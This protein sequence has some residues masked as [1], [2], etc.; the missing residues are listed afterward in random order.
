[1]QTES[2][3]VFLICPC[4]GI[5]TPYVYTFVKQKKVILENR[6]IVCE[7]CKGTFSIKVHLHSGHVSVS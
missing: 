2:R 6:S 5:P 1:M 7:K 4:C 3:R